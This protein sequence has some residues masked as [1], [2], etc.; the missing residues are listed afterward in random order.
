MSELKK[1]IYNDAWFLYKRHNGVNT[2]ERWDVIQLEEKV[3]LEKHNNDPF[4][5]DLFYAINNELGRG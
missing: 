2:D 5:R 4:L 3:L 1:Q